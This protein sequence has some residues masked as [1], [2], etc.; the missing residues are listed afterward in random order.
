MIMENP[1]LYRRRFIPD[2]LVFLK[3]DVIEHIDEQRIVTSWKTIRPRGDFAGGR[4]CYFLDEGYKVSQFFD[5]DG[6]LVYTYCDIISVERRENE[7]I[8]HDLLIDVVIYEDGTV[9]VLD[10]GEIPEALDRGLISVELAKTA[11]NA[12]DRLLDIIY[13]G[14]LNELTR[15]LET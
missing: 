10:L 6:G 8:F 9:K 7:Y 13:S 12:A 1:K 5:K 4:S 15:F 3:D 14:R 11:L 2:E